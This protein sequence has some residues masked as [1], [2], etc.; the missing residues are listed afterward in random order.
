MD[1]KLDTIVFSPLGRDHSNKIQAGLNV[2][3]SFADAPCVAHL[4]EFALTH[5]WHTQPYGRF[6]D[7]VQ[8]D[9]DEVCACERFHCQAFGN[10][11]L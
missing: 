3:H 8:R 7:C 11:F 5:E 9:V 6:G 1:I 10:A 4:W 2:E